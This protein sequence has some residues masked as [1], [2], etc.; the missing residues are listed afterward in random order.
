LF[1]F[2]DID[3]AEPQIKADSTD[4]N[5]LN[6]PCARCSDQTNTD[7]ATAV[8]APMARAPNEWLS[9]SL[10]YRRAIYRGA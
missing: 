10:A 4:S 6:I 7:G 2:V 9:K 3:R 5:G 1:F 8:H